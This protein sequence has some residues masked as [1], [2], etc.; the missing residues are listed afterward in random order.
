MFR[1]SSSSICRPLELLKVRLTP[2]NLPS[3]LSSTEDLSPTGNG[4]QRV[5]LALAVQEI[6]ELE[7]VQYV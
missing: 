1:S 5:W 7:N 6:L 4:N 2:G 3:L